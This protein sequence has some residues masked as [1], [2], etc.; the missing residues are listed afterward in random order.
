MGECRESFTLRMRTRVHKP[1]FQDSGDDGMG[2]EGVDSPTPKSEFRTLLSGRF[3]DSYSRVGY[4]FPGHWGMILPFRTDRVSSD[5]SSFRVGR[6]DWG[7]SLSPGR[8]FSLA[9][10]DSPV[11]V[12]PSPVRPM[13]HRT[14][15]A[16][17][18]TLPPCVGP[19]S[20]VY[21]SLDSQAV[22]LTLPQLCVRGFLGSRPGR[23]RALCEW[24]FAPCPSASA[25]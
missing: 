7:G 18:R 22:V 4:P 8:G 25:S 15:R 11:P 2:F 21:T 14:E 6:Q 20:P 12:H 19:S 3:Q 24:D 16:A 1:G 17:S 13:T 5:Y 10:R 9:L 23:F